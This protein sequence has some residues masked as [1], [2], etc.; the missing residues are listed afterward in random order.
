MKAIGLKP[1][2]T[3][4]MTGNAVCASQVAGASRFQLPLPMPIIERV[5]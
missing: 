1:F 5:N 4:V 2:A 3:N